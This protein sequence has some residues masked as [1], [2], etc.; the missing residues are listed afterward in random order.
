VL[1]NAYRDIYFRIYMTYTYIVQLMCVCVL[2]A[3]SICILTYSVFIVIIMHV[4]FYILCALCMKYNIMYFKYVLFYLTAGNSR[5]WYDSSN[6]GSKQSSQHSHLLTVDHSC[7][8][9][10]TALNICFNLWNW[11]VYIFVCEDLLLLNTFNL[12]MCVC[13]FNGLDLTNFT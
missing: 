9:F 5:G 4:N 11:Y 13:V 7:H 3:P 1:C 2:L 10:F 8:K 12:R 6:L